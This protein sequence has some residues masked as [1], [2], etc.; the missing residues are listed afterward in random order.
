MRHSLNIV[1]A[2][3]ERSMRLVGVRSV[4]EIREHGA[5]FRRQNRLVGNSALPEFVF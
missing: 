5:E 4:E 1:R 3:L 2:E